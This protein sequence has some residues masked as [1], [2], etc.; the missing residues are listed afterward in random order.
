MTGDKPANGPDGLMAYDPDA[1]ALLDAIYSGRIRVARVQTIT[2][3]SYPPEREKDLRSGGEKESVTIQFVNRSPAEV[4]LYWL[5]GDGKR[6]AYGRIASG[7]RTTQNT[8][9]S[10]VWLAAGPDDKALC[11]FV[12]GKKQGLAIVR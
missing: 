7:E 10:H 6:H 12:A 8:F 9:V 11:L 1:Y 4:T 2:L 5:D 3:K